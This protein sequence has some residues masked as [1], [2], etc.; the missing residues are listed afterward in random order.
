MTVGTILP[1]ILAKLSN[2]SE[3]DQSNLGQSNCKNR[4]A[5][6][7]LTNYDIDTSRISLKF[8]VD[9]Q[10]KRNSDSNSSSEK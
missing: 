5:H 7:S 6:N 4:I 10:W 9:F 1:Q 8:H 3:S 2:H